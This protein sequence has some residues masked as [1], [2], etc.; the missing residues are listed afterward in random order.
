MSY[1]GNCPICIRKGIT[2]PLSWVG[3][4]NFCTRC[5][6]ERIYT[7]ENG[8]QVKEKVKA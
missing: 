8:W 1:G 2:V 5:G 7:K 3:N 6:Y 4:R